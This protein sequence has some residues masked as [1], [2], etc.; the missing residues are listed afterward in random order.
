MEADGM[1]EEAKEQGSKNDLKIVD[2][3]FHGEFH[4]R[5]RLTE[6]EMDLDAQMTIPKAKHNHR[7]SKI[8]KK[9]VHKKAR[10]SIIFPSITRKRKGPGV[11]T[12]KR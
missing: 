2:G 1:D 11:L 12:G 8:E 10:N 4:S 6:V 7:K 3:M 5:D 9:K